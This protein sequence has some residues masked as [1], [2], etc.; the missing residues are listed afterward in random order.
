MAFEGHL[1]NAV[2][3]LFSV[4]NLEAVKREVLGLI[5]I[6]DRVGKNGKTA[7]E[8]SGRDQVRAQRAADAEIIKS[9]TAASREKERAARDEAKAVERIQR[10]A[11]RSEL[12]FIKAGQSAI[13][14]AE[15]DRTRI[16]ESE[17]RR[18]QSI[19]EQEARHAESM[20]QRRSR[21]F[22]NLMGGAAG[23][24]MGMAGRVAGIAAAVGGGFAIG[25]ALGAGIKQEEQAGV[26]FRGAAQKGGFT[27]QGAVQKLAVNTAIST[28]GTAEDILGGLDMFVR[29]TGDLGAAE[30]ILEKMAKLSAA[31][32]TNFADM[33]NT[34]AEIQN[35]LGDAAKTMEVMRALVGQGMAGAIDIKDLG[36]YGGRLAAGA[37]QFGGSLAGNIESFGALAQL[38][39]KTGG[40]TDTAEAT[41]A[42]A[43][44]SSDFGK[45][46]EGFAALG[47]DVFTD[48]SRTKFRSAEDIITESVVKSKGD[49]TTLQGLYGER[50]IKAARG[51]QVVYAD[52]GGG[53]AG[54]A[55]IRSQIKGLKSNTPTESDIDAGAAARMKETSAQINVAM[56]KFNR[57]MG[58][59]LLPIMPGMINQF[60]QLIPALARM[61]EAISK[62]VVP[63]IETIAPAVKLFAD[64]MA[65]HPWATIIGGAMAAQIASAGL[66]AVV[67]TSFT[68]IA[69]TA[70]RLVSSTTAS[71]ANVTAGVVNVSSGTP[72]TPT[73]PGGPVPTAV[74]NGLVG[75]GIT[76][77]IA[78]VGLLGA[79]IGTGY[80][81]GDYTK[82]SEAANVSATD[83]INAG[84]GGTSE[85]RKAR[86]EKAQSMVSEIKTH[87]D[88]Y[89]GAVDDMGRPLGESAQVAGTSDKLKALE[90]VVAK[91]ADSLKQVDD[92][93]LVASNAMSAIKKPGADP[94]DV[95]QPPYGP[96][97]TR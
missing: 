81:Y 93:A 21:G 91:L 16:V 7:V 34:T 58:D 84:T 67:T 73:L 27:N 37:A 86:L 45:N 10:D 59:K 1:A 5:P 72:G 49:I 17:A 83:L 14:S 50:S 46:S 40:A 24:V 25:D 95:P 87:K 32:G 54:E 48:K 33:G 43:R 90:A 11:Q 97:N 22:G 41:E 23:R 85:E 82:K 78:G 19:A 15:R 77:G 62:S 18:R 96:G 61:A 60:T 89:G 13:A 39:K 88:T 76:A 70:L 20:L 42:V 71:V 55:A 80:A 12:N 26:I 74:E 52:A 75:G 65:S 63:A 56:T 6:F 79:A 8:S 4:G 68:K 31:T 3:L 47:I 36:Q 38:A 44:L 92:A 29:K 94:P 30:A 57:E 35:Q 51:A 64:M 9:A 69:E 53:A 28:G 66:Q 2:E